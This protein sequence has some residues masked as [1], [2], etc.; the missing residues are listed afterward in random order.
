LAE[1]LIKIINNVVLFKVKVSVLSEENNN[2]R[3]E[4]IKKLNE[5]FDKIGKEN[6]IIKLTTDGV[7]PL[8]DKKDI[9]LVRSDIFEMNFY[10]RDF[11]E[12]NAY[13]IVPKKE[14][15]SEVPDKKD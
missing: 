3:N 15:E 2:K 8:L 11:Q 5:K 10:L 13:N 7:R 6:E 12:N 4:Y 9:N 14:K 1:I